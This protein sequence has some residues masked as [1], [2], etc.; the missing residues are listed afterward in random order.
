V[1]STTARRPTGARPDEDDTAPAP[2]A[3]GRSRKK[4][5]LLAAPLL[6]AAAGGWFFLGGGSGEEEPLPVE[7]G[8]VVRLDSIHLN[9]AEGRYLKLGLALQATAD[10]EEAPDGSRAQDIAISLLSGRTVEELS[11]VETREALKAQLV[12]QVGE[13]Y[14]DHVMD[15]YFWEFVTQ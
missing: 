8:A 14:E 1:A 9:L 6:A 11:S 7:P 10:A 2:A 13:A 3:P 12:E 4:V 15:V 5:L